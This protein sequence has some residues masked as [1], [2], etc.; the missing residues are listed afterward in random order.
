[1]TVAATTPTRYRW[2]LLRAG[3]FRLDGGSMFGLIPRTVWSRTAPV[4]DRGRIEVQH[5]CLLLE[6][7]GDGPG[8]KI[9]LLEAG[10]GDKL[11]AASR[12]LFAL[13]DRT[14][15][16]ALREV[17]CDPRDVGAAIT[18]HLHFDHA[19]GLTMLA[20]PGEKADWHGPASGMA[21]ARPDHGVRFAFPNATLV[22]Q[23]REWDDA[24]AGRS[25]MTR[26]YF[27]DHLHPFAPAHASP[28]AVAAAHDAVRE[29]L[30]LV[31][32]PRPFPTGVTPDRDELPRT[33]VE[34]RCT[35]VPGVPGVRVMLCPGHTW[36][37]QAMLFEDTLGRTVVFTPDVMP[38]AW[39]VGAA[40]SLAYD[41][42]PY[43]SMVTKRWLLTAAAERD[44][45]LVLD[46]EAGNP[47]RRVRPTARGW[48]DLV[49]DQ[50]GQG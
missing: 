43:T 25:V 34:Q 5:N 27:A 22:A 41:V 48:F 8:P 11:D 36:G 38:T 30:I 46:H 39:H 42:E 50:A 16:D 3:S 13:Q 44:W 7:D 29:R 10:T 40:Y 18:T 35:P 45:L 33:T 49:E 14:V 23:R 9:V 12:D 4:D 17:N 6:R 32:S 19:G 15:V 21:G 20:K 31:D 28:R 47:C 26:T 2:R 24:M 1:M 37:Q